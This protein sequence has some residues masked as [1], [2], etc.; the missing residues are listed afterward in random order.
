VPDAVIT[1]TC[2]PDD[3]W[4]NHLKQVEQFTEI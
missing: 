2:A 3:E 4:S 1:V